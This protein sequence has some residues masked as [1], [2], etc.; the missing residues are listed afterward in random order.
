MLAIFIVFCVRKEDLH[1]EIFAPLVVSFQERHRVC[2]VDTQGSF[3][4]AAFLVLK[5]A[6]DHITTLLNIRYFH[7]EIIQA[8]SA[9]AVD[10]LVFIWSDLPA[11]DN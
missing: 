10:I 4:L 2:T 3:T 7:V 5:E 11:Q 9:N 8:L 6:T 1:Q